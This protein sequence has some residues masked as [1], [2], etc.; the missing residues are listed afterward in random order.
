LR[1]KDLIDPAKKMS[2]SDE[3][4]KGIIFLG[5]NPE[6]AAKKVMGA[7]TDSLASI[8]L[9][10]EKQPGI[11]N[12]LQILALL[13][14]E[15]LGK[16]KTEWE[17]KSSYGE[18]KGAVA[19]AVKQFLIDFQAKVGQ[20]DEAKLNSKLSADEAKMN[21][22]ANATLVKVQKAVGLRP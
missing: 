12:L 15:D 11:F 9:D 20:V 2:K 21:E 14:S 10:Y 18:L 6:E 1:I 16:V 7:T 13:K 22:I 19:E 3:S 5:D 8:H 17:G 4:A